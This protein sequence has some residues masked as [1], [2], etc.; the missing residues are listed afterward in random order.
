MSHYRTGEVERLQLQIIAIGLGM[1]NGPLQGKGVIPIAL[2][3]QCENRFATGHRD[4]S[5]APYPM[6]DAVGDRHTTGRQGR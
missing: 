5:I 1:I 3:Q 6:V 2:N 4:Q